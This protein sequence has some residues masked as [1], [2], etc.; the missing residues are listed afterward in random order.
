[1]SKMTNKFSSEVRARA[2]RMVL[3]H[4]G[5]HTSSWAGSSGQRWIAASGRACLS[6]LMAAAS[7]GAFM[8]PCFTP[9]AF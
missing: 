7:P 5:K 4:V 8:T 6:R 9:P 1:M 2:L 3:D